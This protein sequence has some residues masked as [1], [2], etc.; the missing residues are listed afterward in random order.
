MEIICKCYSS[1]T[2]NTGTNMNDDNQQLKIMP[3]KMISLIFQT[4][5]ACMVIK[6]T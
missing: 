2:L 3:S 4:K 6:I 1:W 5:K